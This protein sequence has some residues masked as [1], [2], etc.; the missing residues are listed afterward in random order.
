MLRDALARMKERKAHSDLFQGTSRGQGAEG[1]CTG[2]RVC[3]DHIAADVAKKKW[4]E[5]LPSALCA[6]AGGCWTGSRQLKAGYKIT[7][8]TLFC[9]RCGDSPDT[10]HHRLWI[11]PETEKER[12]EVFKSRF[13]RE[14]ERKAI[15]AEDKEHPLYTR[16][17]LEHPAS[18]ATAPG[19][20]R[21]GDGVEWEMSCD[22][23][24]KLGGVAYTDGS[25]DTH[26]V[27]ALRRA[28]WAVIFKDEN[29]AE[30]GRVRGPVWRPFP[31]TPQAA[32][33]IAMAV[34]AQA[35]QQR[36]LVYADCWNVIAAANEL[37]KSSGPAPNRKALAYDGA[38][39][40]GFEESWAQEEAF[41]EE[42]RWQK[43]H[44]DVNEAGISEEERKHRQGNDEADAEAKKA[45][46]QERDRFKDT[47]DLDPFRAAQ[48]IWKLMK[49]TLCKWPPPTRNLERKE[50]VRKKELVVTHNWAKTEGNKHVCKNCGRTARR[51][52][53]QLR[54]Q[55]CEAETLKQAM[56]QASAVRGHKLRCRKWEGSAFIFC[57]RCGGRTSKRTPRRGKVLAEP[58]K[59]RPTSKGAAVSLRR[60]M[61]ERHPLKN[62][63][64]EGYGEN[65]EEAR[66]M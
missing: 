15:E 8:E 51:L 7:P 26:A 10:L 16:A 49:A 56:Q 2:D 22:A 45:A 24:A 34:C 59:G 46:Q 3:I 13:A 63:L 12:R 30:Q 31:Q 41:I 14:V 23:G 48:L 33:F 60:M 50:A 40:F 28:G 54:S 18:Q 39:R 64:F 9:S 32:E 4:E 36:T 43:A 19:E 62:K 57:T 29:G 35:V 65:K 52:S 5:G 20:G 37:R 11:C 6:E 25:C 53:E 66:R 38:L 1:A 17:L 27:V 61:L 21:E 58:C 42:V 47:V 55:Q 44:C